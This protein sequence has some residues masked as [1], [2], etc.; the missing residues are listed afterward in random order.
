MEN[1][2]QMMKLISAQIEE[3]KKQ[4]H[5]IIRIKEELLY[6]FIQVSEIKEELKEI[7]NKL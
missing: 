1:E 3:L 2:E 4:Y 6:I 7:N 5:N